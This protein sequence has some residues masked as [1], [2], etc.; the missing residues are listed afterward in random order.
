MH[1]SNIICLRVKP[2]SSHSSNATARLILCNRVSHPLHL[3]KP[4]IATAQ[5]RHSKNP[6]LPLRESSTTHSPPQL[7]DSTTNLPRPSHPSCASASSL[8]FLRESVAIFP[9]VCPHFCA[10]PTSILHESVAH[11]AQKR[12]H[13]RANSSP[14]SH[15][16]VAIFA[17]V[18]HQF[19]DRGEKTN[20]S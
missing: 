18:G 15:K 19:S 12:Y 10:N 6:P 5:T 17:P 9:K 11:L 4:S 14:I 16:F 2:Q 13:S 7:H 1:E 3:S 20:S 8:L